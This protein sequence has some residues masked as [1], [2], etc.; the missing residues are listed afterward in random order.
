[1]I[2]FENLDPEVRDHVEGWWGPSWRSREEVRELMGYLAGLVN[3]GITWS[4]YKSLVGP[5][6]EEVFLPKNLDL[7]QKLGLPPASWAGRKKWLKRLDCLFKERLTCSPLLSLTPEELK[8]FPKG[9]ALTSKEFAEYAF[10]YKYC[11]RYRTPEEVI[12]TAYIKVEKYL[13]EVERTSSGI[14]V[15]EVIEY[16]KN[17]HDP[18][19][20]L[21]WFCS[22]QEQGLIDKAVWHYRD[23]AWA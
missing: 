2:N 9:R 21:N 3:P 8:L 12:H 13:L 18:E 4:R 19:Q 6:V 20:N 11:I 1:M 14:M 22:L 23:E 7:F 16:E 10:R 17:D 15:S 5:L